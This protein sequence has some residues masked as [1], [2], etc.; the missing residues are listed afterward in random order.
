MD[1]INKFINQNIPATKFTIQKQLSFIVFIYI[2]GSADSNTHSYSSLYSFSSIHHLRPLS[3]FPNMF[4][5]SQ[6][7]TDIKIVTKMKSKSW[8][9]ES[10][11]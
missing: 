3:C 6:K 5:V 11:K 4:F 8:Q 1:N 2:L 9:F 7:S 10:K